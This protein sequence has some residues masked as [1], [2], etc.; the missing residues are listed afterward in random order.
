VIFT[1]VLAMPLDLFLS[2]FSL[3]LP[4]PFLEQL[5]QASFHSSIFIY[6]YKIHPPYS[7]SFPLSFCPPPSIGTHV[8]KRPIFTSCPSFLLVY[9]DS[10]MG[11][12]PWTIIYHALIKLI[13]FN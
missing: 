9:I 7:P 12:S 2:S 6:G 3:F 1:Y 11:V 8:W 4:H 5:H 13:K 10:P